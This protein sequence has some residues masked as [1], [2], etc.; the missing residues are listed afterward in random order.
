[1]YIWL[2][3]AFIFAALEA[4]AVSKNLRRLE[5]A[6]KP[7]VMVCLFLW[8]YSIT[9]LQGS[10]FWF[11][12]GIVFS[13]AGDV[14]LMA[15]PDRLFL[16]GLIAFLFAHFSYITGFSKEIAAAS[17]W[18]LLLLILIAIGASRLLRQIVAAMRT[19]GQ[20][21]L[22]VPVVIYGIVI[23]VMLYAALSTIYDPV[24]KTSAALFVSLGAFLF[25]ISDLILAWNKFVSPINNGRLFNIMTYHLGQIGL[26][27]GIISQFA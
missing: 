21:Q 23:S 18:S 24:W 16:F 2:I 3:L 25:W 22:I 7:A 27:A 20:N 5:Y 13:L 17:A 8:L 12:A 14:L 11:G 15:A 6:A 19:K 9:G 4:T 10:A 1:M 26:I